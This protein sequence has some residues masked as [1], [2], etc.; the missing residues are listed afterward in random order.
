M[1]RAASDTLGKINSEQFQDIQLFE[2]I[3]LAEQLALQPKNWK[4][5]LHRHSASQ[6]MSILYGQPPLESVH[7]PSVE[8]IVHFGLYL[9]RV[10]G[11]GAHLVE[12]I[13]WLRFIPSRYD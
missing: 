4:Q 1:R 10:L 9:A 11:H 13:P 2:A 12:L 8:N 5:L 7:D 6:I 3:L